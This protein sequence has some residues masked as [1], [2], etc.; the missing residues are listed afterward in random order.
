MLK[1]AL[2]KRAT[3]LAV[4]FMVLFAA[5]V[6][7]AQDM[8]VLLGVAMLIIAVVLEFIEKRRL[9]HLQLAIS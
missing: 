2:S 6:A 7:V 1:P 5:A 9:Q 4:I 3:V 8:T